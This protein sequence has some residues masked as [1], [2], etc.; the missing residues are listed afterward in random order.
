MNSPH[1]PLHCFAV[2]HVFGV[3]LVSPYRSQLDVEGVTKAF[4]KFDKDKDVIHPH[5]VIITAVSQSKFGAFLAISF[6][7]FHTFTRATDFTNS[8]VCPVFDHEFRHN[9]VKIDFDNVMTK[10]IVNNWSDT[11]IVKLSALARQ[12]KA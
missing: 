10:F 8:C 1:I 11:L 4:R 3:L 5:V 2:F 7:D 9:I 12:L 6:P